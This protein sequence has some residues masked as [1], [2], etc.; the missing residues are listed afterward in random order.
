MCPFCP[1]TSYTEVMLRHQAS[2]CWDN[3]LPFFCFVS[4]CLWQTLVVWSQCVD[5]I[6]PFL[7]EFLESNTQE[8]TVHVH[9]VSLP[10]KILCHCH[11]D[12]FP[13]CSPPCQSRFSVY[14]C[15]PSLPRN[16][17][18]TLYHIC[19]DWFGR[20]L[21][22]ESYSALPWPNGL[23]SSQVFFRRIAFLAWFSERV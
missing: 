7:F 13:L 18:M 15:G 6:S 5:S 16:K 12:L 17:S 8:E 14:W 2:C 4:E 19:C 22:P 23:V 21:P 10:M 9:C 1:N 20:V 3:I 11:C